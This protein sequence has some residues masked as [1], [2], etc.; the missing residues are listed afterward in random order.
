MPTNDE[1]PW[2]VKE[3]KDWAKVASLFAPMNLA[4][5]EGEKTKVAILAEK[6][7]LRKAFKMKIADEKAAQKA[8]KKEQK[9]K[10]KGKKGKAKQQA[11]ASNKKCALDDPY[12]KWAGQDEESPI[13]F[14]ELCGTIEYAVEDVLEDHLDQKEIDFIKMVGLQWVVGGGFVIA[15]PLKKQAEA[16]KTEDDAQK[17]EKLKKTLE[18][19][20][21]SAMKKHIVLYLREKHSSAPRE[22]MDDVVGEETPDEQI[23]SGA[24]EVK[25]DPSRF[26]GVVD[27]SALQDAVTMVTQ[28]TRA[29]KGEVPLIPGPG[30]QPN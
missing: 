12:A 2:L 9:K 10:K 24:I 1:Y 11:K 29:D 6:A 18:K 15:P 28:E 14:T 19:K 26:P 16:L 4:K 27:L 22:D 23:T 8:Q 21:W 20:T 17:I 25:L 30:T 3:R 7:Q 5:K 13:M